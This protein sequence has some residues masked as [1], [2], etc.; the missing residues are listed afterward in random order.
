MVP[1]PRSLFWLEIGLG[2]IAALCLL[3]AFHAY[4]DSATLSPDPYMIDAQP[5]RW[6]EALHILPEKIVAGYLSDLSFEVPAGSAAY[7]GVAN[8]LAPRLIVRSADTSQWVVG[9]F[10]RPADFAAAGNA[11]G[12]ELIRDFGNGVVVYRRRSQ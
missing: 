12:L 5:L 6:R 1:A 7:F 3:S 9:N 10:S 8:A 4:R 11:H 2:L